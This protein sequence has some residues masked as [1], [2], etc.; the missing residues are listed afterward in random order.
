MVP[1]EECNIIRGTWSDFCRYHR[2]SPSKV[3]AVTQSRR[4]ESF[5][6]VRRRDPWNL[7]IVSMKVVTSAEGDEAYVP[8]GAAQ[9]RTGLSQ[10]APLLASTV[11]PGRKT[12]AFRVRR[13]ASTCT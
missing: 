1:G 4:K 5:G 8:L 11:S 10:K 3:C 6:A 13:P 9:T 7:E 12:S 2:A